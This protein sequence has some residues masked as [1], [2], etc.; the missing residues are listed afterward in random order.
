MSAFTGSALI[1]EDRAWLRRWS[2][3]AMVAVALHGAVAMAVLAWHIASAPRAG[4][5]FFIDLPPLLDA[6]SS[7]PSLPQ[8]GSALD[9]SAALPEPAED[10]PGGRS[11]VNRDNGMEAAGGQR[12]AAQPIAAAPIVPVS[13][14]SAERDADSAGAA[15]PPAFATD[16]ANATP[17][18]A[19][20]ALR[21]DPGPIDTSITVGPPVY[22]HETAS[23]RNRMILRRSPTQ[24]GKAEPTPA[25]PGALTNAPGVHGGVGRGSVSHRP[26]AHVEDRVN[27]AIERQELLRRIERARNGITAPGTNALG[28][29]NSAGANVRDHA[30][31][32]IGAASAHDGLGGPKSGIS[33]GMVTVRNAIGMTTEVRP[34]AHGIGVDE[35]A[36]GIA[37]LK[38]GISPSIAGLKTAAAPAGIL[39][40]RGMAR[41]GMSL[42]TLGG[43]AKNVSGVLNGSDFRA[44][45]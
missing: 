9:R 5:P 38:T 15:G 32:A 13:P 11:A 43:P 39:N 31:N 12:N 22:R 27:A 26:G 35:R 2:V 19:S 6:G 40:G 45:R 28:I 37:G 1:D 16:H 18:A 14:G 10:V 44:K 41:A 20:H 21:V 3:S 33:N 17:L 24:P 25:N 23:D 36:G 34:S 29:K 8:P 4:G 7:Q 42:T 30:R